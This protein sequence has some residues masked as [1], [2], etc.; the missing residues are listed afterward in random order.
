MQQ[1]APWIGV[2]L[3]PLLVTTALAAT[4]PAPSAQNPQRH[5]AQATGQ[6]ITKLGSAEGW[7]AFSDAV[8][9]HK[10]CYLIGKP[11]KSEPASAKRGPIFAS[12]THRPSEKRTNEVSFTVGYLFKEGSDAELTVDG[13]KFSLFTN[14]EG[15]WAQDATTDKAVVEALAKGKQA[16][17]KGTSVRGTQTTD[18]Y[19]LAGFS[20]ALAQIDKACGIKR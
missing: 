3:A 15:A 17:I 9:G 16:V 19:S 8:K 10:I 13:K 5:A 11:A 20:Q 14:K 1:H 7:D 2:A 12:V 4:A 18:T 6:D